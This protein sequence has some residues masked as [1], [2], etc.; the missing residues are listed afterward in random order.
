MR[1]NEPV[2]NREIEMD[3]HALIVSK[4]DLAGRITFFNRTFLEIS[5]YNEKE[6][7]GA[8]HNI[9]RHPHMPSEAFEDL[10]KTV[11]AGWPWE[12][13]VKNRTKSGDYYWVRANVTPLTENGE[14]IGYISVR[15]KASRT[16][17]AAAEALYKTMRERP[18]AKT[19]MKIKRGQVT[20]DTILGLFANKSSS[21]SW[22][23]ILAAMALVIAG[24]LST[25]IGLF[26]MN[27]SNETVRRVAVE[28]VTP[29]TDLAQIQYLLQDGRYQ[30][31]HLLRSQTDGGEIA[32][33]KD[34]LSRADRIWTQ[35]SSTRVP[36]AERALIDVFSDK[37]KILTARGF[38]P[39]L[40]ASN[41]R[42]ALRTLLNGALDTSLA[43]SLSAL[44]ALQA[45]QVKAAT[46]EA[47]DASDNLTEH[48]IGGGAIMVLGMLTGLLLGRKA[49]RS[50]Q[51]A[52]SRMEDSFAAIA[53]DNTQSTVPNEAVP[54]F[55]NT[56][57][58]L[59]SM[60]ARLAYRAEEAVEL[61]VRTR[62]TLRHEMITLT[63]ALEGEIQESVS[64]I[65]TQS[66]RLME[67]AESLLKVADNLRQITESV[68]QA[69]AVTAGNVQT[70]ASATEE[71]E[72]SSRTIISQV[73]N[74]SRLAEDASL[75]ADEA[76]ERVSGLTQATVQIGSVVNMIRSISGQTR[77]LALNATIEAERAGEA[78]RGFAVVA[79][80]VKGLAR[81][82]DSGIVDVSAHVDAI[83]RTT[84]ETV[85]T[86]NKVVAAIREIDT[87]S[88][89]VSRG[90]QEQRAATA[91]IMS[92]A[93]QASDNTKAVSQHMLEVKAGVK[94]THET[95]IMVNN[96][97]G[98][99][100]KDIAA[101]DRRFSIIL[102]ASF[103]GNRRQSERV[104]VAIRFTADIEGK[105]YDGFT[106]DLSQ[107]GALL[108]MSTK[109]LPTEGRGTIDFEG[110]G[111][112]PAQVLSDSVSGVHVCFD[113]L[114]SD[115]SKTL[116]ARIQKAV[117][118]DQIYIKIAQDV[119][120]QA[121]HSWENAIRSGKISSAALF[122]LEY[123]PIP[124]TNP[125]QLMTAYTQLA[126]TL[127]QATIEAP[128]Q[129]NSGVI[130]C[131]I[132]DRSGYL[133][134]HN[135]RYSHPQKPDD[136]AWNTAHCR[137]RRV[138]DDRTGILAARN[139]K[140]HLAQT[141]SRDMGG[142]SFALLKE[143]DVPITVNGQHWGAVRLGVKLF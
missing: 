70:V 110:I 111:K 109:D 1:V 119:A 66:T 23:T 28:R 106:G 124:D 82:T 137:N 120:V 34:D 68:T 96:L 24:G 62:E 90:A 61:G 48:L 6:L 3:D 69:I 55:V 20:N 27:Q 133:P 140:P 17:I 93:I 99:V 143:V 8:P 59:R 45:Y 2:T 107:H 60:R 10:W 127:L 25:A 26:G 78:G 73:D 21:L 80:E 112:L 46:E 67:G 88:A 15:T 94:S 89:E 19:K 5:G 63:E 7:M 103:G 30:L 58:M 41:D 117:T 50:L 98:M 118:D 36:D 136:I 4:T 79:D 132:S 42:D 44:Q 138:F 71:L 52:L 83:G 51:G 141:Y 13:L 142:G 114:L 134:V 40:A 35:Y 116:T 11:K 121:A 101:L 139:T 54:E 72:A 56:S 87:I 81:Q 126:E 122:Q 39:A 9:L 135:I 125:L 38:E 128:L 95:A 47:H 131:C 65:S 12:G 92:S 49:I 29:Q 108:V 43:E 76:A 31:D 16:E 123:H 14:Q 75:M 113:E 77:M 85:E 129:T 22:Q 102:R 32:K 74:S 18:S 105:A 91:E 86:V 57:T 104:P 37:R 115:A 64:D 130:F 53:A 33:V 84:G 97:A 100:F